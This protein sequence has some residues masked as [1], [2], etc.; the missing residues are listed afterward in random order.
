VDPAACTETDAA[1]ACPAGRSAEHWIV[2]ALSW[3][4][5]LGLVALGLLLHPDPRGYG[6]HEQ[7][8]LLPCLPMALWRIPCPGCG[9]TTSVVAVLH[10]QVGAALVDQPF[11][12]FIVLATFGAA[13]G[14]TALHLRG[15]DAKDVLAALP[16]GKVTLG[17]GGLLVACWFYKVAALRSWIG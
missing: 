9:V 13:L 17:V 7:L 2:L 4:G 16:M 3:L 5:V 11:G 8:G 1:G 6:T 14:A 10:G 12:L 15:R